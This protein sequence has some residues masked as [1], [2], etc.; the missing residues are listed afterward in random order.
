[1]K[2]EFDFRYLKIGEG[3]ETQF[4]ARNGVFQDGTI[5][6]CRD[7]HGV[8][9]AIAGHSHCGHIAMYRGSCVEELEQVY[10]IQ[11]GFSVGRAGEAFYG[12]CYPEGILPR[13]SI[14]PFGLYICP[15]TH[16]FFCFFHNETGWNGQGTAYDSFGSCIVP[17]YDS[18]FRH[19]GLMHSDDEGRNWV[20]D[21]WVLTAEQ[22]CCSERHIPEGE[23]IVGQS[24]RVICLGSGD[25]SLFNDPNSEYLYLF[26][27]I[28]YVDLD[29][30]VWRRCD[31]YLAR[32]RKRADGVMGDFVKFYDGAFSEP[33]NMGRE[34]PVVKNAWHSRVAYA[35]SL[36]C[37][38]MTSTKMIPDRPLA[39]TLPDYMEIRTSENLTDWSE[40]CSVEYGG[41]LFGNHYN[42]VCSASSTLPPEVIEEEFLFLTGHNG[43]DVTLYQAKM[44]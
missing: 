3:R 20:F 21:R 24:G 6:M 23:N 17:K 2:N 25:F 32:T 28:I 15:I 34:S 38:M 8:L 40:P 5:A 10:P 18:D 4:A 22:V 16:R 19:I 26:Y 29:K 31:T 14:W 39:Q 13:G 44:C 35:A 41:K 7:D 9:W 42:A 30:G 11:T 1:M 43:T 12:I 36:E 33:G 37:Y 27:N